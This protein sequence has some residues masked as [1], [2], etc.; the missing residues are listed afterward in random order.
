[1]QCFH[2][3]VVQPLL[4]RSLL[5]QSL[6]PPPTARGFCSKQWSGA[7]DRP[8]S[9]RHPGAAG[10]ITAWHPRPHRHFPPPGLARAS[11][12]RPR[13]APDGGRPS[14]NPRPGGLLRT[15]VSGWFEESRVRASFNSGGMT[16]QGRRAQTQRGRVWRS[17]PEGTS[18]PRPSRPAARPPRLPARVC[19][20]A[21]A[22]ASAHAR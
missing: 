16:V 21:D 6:P 7:L 4:P 11:R 22:G 13:P 14:S 18:S 19:G 1:M 2:Q 17:C 3:P 8:R 5:L 9:G 10:Y 15:A 20:P 12:S